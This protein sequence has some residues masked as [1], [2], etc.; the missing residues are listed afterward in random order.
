MST[1]AYIATCPRCK[2]EAFESLRT[3]AH[4]MECLYFQTHYEDF[5][6]VSTTALLVEKVLKSALTKSIRKKKTKK[7]KEVSQ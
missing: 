6:T 2:A 1:N 3:H 4:C 5:D 7:S